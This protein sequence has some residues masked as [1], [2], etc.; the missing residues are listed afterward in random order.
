MAESDRLNAA[1]P[2][3]VAQRP[4]WS[5]D[6][7]TIAYMVLQSAEDHNH[8]NPTL[9]TI[10]HHMGYRSHSAVCP[11]CNRTIPKH[12]YRGRKNKSSIENHSLPN[13]IQRPRWVVRTAYNELRASTNN[14]C[15]SSPPNSNCD[16]RS[17]TQIVSISLP[18]ESYT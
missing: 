18:D 2:A 9:V 10:G 6:G 12:L 7:R 13:E 17:G 8:G 16:G 5:L 1:T 3:C 15:P 4:Y 14:V 11:F